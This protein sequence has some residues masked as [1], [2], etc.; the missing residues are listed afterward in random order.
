MYVKTNER[1]G[2]DERVTGAIENPEAYLTGI[3]MPPGREHQCRCIRGDDDRCAAMA[4]PE[5]PVCAE[6]AAHH[7]NHDGTSIKGEWR[8]AN[9]VHPENGEVDDEQG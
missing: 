2:D 3:E 7:W 5:M 9:Q 1:R 6:C 8:L 4:M